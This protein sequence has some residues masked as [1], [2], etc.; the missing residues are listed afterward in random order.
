MSVTELISMCSL[1]ESDSYLFLKLTLS[2]ANVHE[3]QVLFL[4]ELDNIYFALAE[5]VDILR[6]NSEDCNHYTAIGIVVIW[7]LCLQFHEMWWVLSGEV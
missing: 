6:W 3:W 7:S 5:V 1:L 2:I 4:C